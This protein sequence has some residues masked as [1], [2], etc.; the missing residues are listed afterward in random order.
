MDTVEFETFLAVV[1]CGSLIRASEA[2]HTSQS[3]VSHRLQNLE[4]G[5]G[6]RLLERSPGQRGITLTAHG[7]EFLRIAEKWELL[8]HEM[9]S[10]GHR[11]RDSLAIGAPDSLRDRKSTRLN[12][13][14]VR[15]S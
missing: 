7:T 15:I 8:A 1:R 5:L 2:L 14:H 4:A 13:S 3:T 10:V 12:S 9:A 6:V 11:R